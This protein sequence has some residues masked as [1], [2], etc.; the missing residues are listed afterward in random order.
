[1]SRE[2]YRQVKE[3][4]LRALDLAGE[5]RSAFLESLGHADPALRAEVESLLVHDPT[6]ARIVETGAIGRGLGARLAESLGATPGPAAPEHVGSYELLQV[7][8]EGGMGTVYRAEQKD[9]HPRVVALKVI[10][11]GF[12]SDRAVARFELERQVLS[13]MSHPGIARVFD[14][15]ADEG[16]RL[17]FAMELVEGEPITEYCDHRRLTV[18]E[19]L[20]IFLQVCD[21]VQYAHRRGIVHRDLKPS[22]ILITESGG[23]VVA[24]VIDFGI[25]KAVQDPSHGGSQ[26][27]QEGQFVGTPAYMSPEQASGSDARVD[28]KSDVYALGVVLYTLVAGKPPYDL[29]DLTPFEMLRA[30]R[31]TEP[32]PPS[33]AY[34]ADGPA[35]AACRARGG[36]R[37]MLMLQLEGPIDCISLTALRKAPEERYAAVVDLAEDIQRYLAGRPISAT[38][39]RRGPGANVAA[40]HNLPAAQ[41]SFVGRLRELDECRELLDE[42]RILTLL[43][44]GGCGKTRLAL[45]LADGALH[46]CPDGVWFVDLSPLTDASRVP[47]LL[48]AVLG[49]PEESERTILQ[50]L[51]QYCSKRR[52]LVVLDNCEHVLE[53]CREV[54][55]SLLAAAP[56]VKIVATSRERLGLGGEAVYAVPPLSL[57][58]EDATG[59]LSA[60]EASDAV[61]LFRDRARL[62]Q[63]GYRLTEE[64]APIVVEICRRLDGIPLALELAAAWVKVIAPEQIRA[65]LTERFRLLTSGSRNAPPRHQTLRAA[66]QW[67]YD[68]LETGEQRLLRVVS[69]FAGGWTLESG[70]AVVGTTDEVAILGPLA[71]LVDKSLVVVQA[72]GARERRYR[73][74]DTVRAF[75]QEELERS[76]VGDDAATRHMTYF[77][78]LAEEADRKLLGPEQAEWFAR[79]ER[80]HENVLAALD[81]CRHVEDGVEAGLRIVGALRVFW[82]DLGYVR[83]G[84]QRAEEVLGRPGAEGPTRAR[85]LALYGAGSLAVR[86]GLL[87]RANSLLEE[88]V[89]IARSLGDRLLLAKSLSYLGVAQTN[90]GNCVEAKR[91]HSESVAIARELGDKL[92]LAG[93]LH[94]LADL[95]R[96]Q[97]DSNG[98]AQLYEESLGLAREFGDWRGVAN[99]LANI[100]LVAVWREDLE[101]A[102][103]RMIECIEVA[104]QGSEIPIRAIALDVAAGL[105]TAAGDSERA[106]RTFAAASAAWQQVGASRE[107]VDEWHYSRALA[108][109]RERLGPAGFEVAST[110]GRSMS[111][112]AATTEALRWLKDQEFPARG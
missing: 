99:T 98:A 85:A 7:L 107:P 34:S 66:L 31:E 57:P 40:P 3:A 102:R 18:H 95:C 93:S 82:W 14:A 13:M 39:P 106:A 96:A 32:E 6:P 59:G 80:E 65:K 16:G 75:A 94:N 27:T 38:S 15:G 29:E 79:L 30:V 92:E 26:L 71:R 4:A 22:N 17:Y 2:G 21:A 24:K 54:A 10:R 23:E 36:T 109:V 104:E 9:P 64:D 47:F 97:G 70:A 58:A 60:A 53:A 73:L 77:L 37:E 51:A 48:A 33:R 28:A 61:I 19:R 35:A 52:A 56:A 105:A 86:A 110:A 42:V 43:G 12:A 101:T 91:A 112:E 55:G 111:V 83:L 74:L 89:G 84:L 8:G 50:S 68:Q 44:V 63:P 103:T 67:S 41:T 88:S 100:A 49:V 45:R 25:A 46:S 81:Q 90:Q 62:V 78:Q 69:V 5:A 72:G 1:M 76:E 108:S 11:R 20:E 87:A